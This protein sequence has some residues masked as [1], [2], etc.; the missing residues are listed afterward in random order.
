MNEINILNKINDIEDD[1]INE[2]LTHIKQQ[3]I[4]EALYQGHSVQLNKPMRGDVKKFKVYVKNKSGKIV[5]VNFGS[6]DYNIKKNNPDRKKSYCSRS[7]GIEGG[8]TDKTKANYWSRRMW[9]C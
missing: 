5:K 9:N 7:K 8:G 3:I 6:K 1:E 2:L 4:S